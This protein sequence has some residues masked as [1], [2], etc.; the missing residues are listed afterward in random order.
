MDAWITNT[1][2]SFFFFFRS[3]L[4]LSQED[5]EVITICFFLKLGTLRLTRF[6][7]LH[8]QTR[9]REQEWSVGMVC[10]SLSKM[11]SFKNSGKENFQWKEKTLEGSRKEEIWLDYSSPPKD[12]CFIGEWECGRI[13]VGKQVAETWEGMGN[14]ETASVSVYP[15]QS[16]C[17]VPAV[18][19]V[20]QK[21]V[22]NLFAE[23][24][25]L[26]R[27]KDFK[28]SLVQYVEGL[29]VADYAASDEVTIPKELLCKLHVNRAA[30]YFAM[31]SA[32]PRHPRE[33]GRTAG[34]LWVSCSWKTCQ[35]G[36]QPPAQK[37]MV[38]YRELGY[39]LTITLC[40]A[41]PEEWCKGMGSR[42]CWPALRY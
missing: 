38:T 9:S 33:S 40:L 8:S 31:V 10:H 5:Y 24:N 11:S 21:L 4:P 37:E 14:W 34:L 1:F 3:T 12:S 6:V 35:E 28:L 22:R 25:D 16:V 29:N 13:V 7:L 36:I 30:C 26:F 41:K 2:S 17:S 23:G 15:F 42:F 19:A 39:L 20:L 18:Q 32:F 27:E